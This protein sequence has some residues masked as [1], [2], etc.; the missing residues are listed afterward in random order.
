[1]R[2]RVLGSV[3]F[4]FGVLALVFAG[5]L[6]FVVAPTA[7]QLPY[8]MQLTQS[9]AEASNA[10]FLQIAD[11]KATVET[12][13]LRSTVTVQPDPAAT[14]KLEGDLDGSALVWLAGQEVIRTDTNEVVSAY[15]TS[16]AVDR[17]SGAAQ[18]WNGQWLDTGN[19]REDISYSGQVYKFPFGTEKQTYQYFDRDILAAQPAQFVKTEEI[20]GLETYQFT[21][22][23][24]DAEQKLPADRVKL[25]LGQLIPGATDGK[26]AYNNTKT[27]WVEPTTG[28]YIKVEEQQRKSLVATDG[29]SVEILNA[30]FT[31]TNDTTKRAAETAKDNISKLNLVGL[32]GPIA[33][34]VIGLILLIAGGVLAARGSKSGGAGVPAQGGRHAAPSG[35]ANDRTEPIASG[36]SAEK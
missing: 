12:G 10:R 31:Y 27:V 28:Q 2:S 18:E 9:V 1:M 34:A 26:V 5:G 30:V 3:L 6:A 7:A 21:Q 20:E 23:I 4:G 13:N 35:G 22:Q 25:L 15:S 8:D 14:A 11:A 32:Y 17:K 33:L 19:D 24:T 36:S 16:L 29:R